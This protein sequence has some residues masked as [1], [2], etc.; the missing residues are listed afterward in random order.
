[1]YIRTQDT[2]PGPF[3]AEPPAKTYTAPITNGGQ[4]I[5]EDDAQKVLTILTG[6]S[7]YQ[8][9]IQPIM[10]AN[11]SKLPKRFLRIVSSVSEVPEHLRAR[12]SSGDNKVVGGTIDRSTGTIYMLPPP[13][14]RSDTR[15]EFAL[16]EAVH[17]LAHPFMGIV[18]ERTFL[19]NY[20]PPCSR[21]TSIGTF[22]RKFCWGPGEGLTQLITEQIM[23]KQNISKTKSER[24]YK[25]MV[26]PVRELMRIYS[27]DA[28]ARAYFWG[29]VRQLTTAIEF[30]WGNGWRIVAHHTSRGETQKALDE[31]KKLE[32]AFERVKSSWPKGDFPDPS[33]YRNLA[34]GPRAGSARLSGL[35]ETSPKP[36][37]TGLRTTTRADKSTPAVVQN[38]I[39]QSPFLKP[40]LA[41]KIGKV[42]IAKNY[43][44]YGSDA[45]FDFAYLKLNK[46]VVPFGSAEEKALLNIRRFFHR[47]NESI[48]LRPTSN[49]GHALQMAI[50]K[51][52]SPGF[53]GFFG[54][55]LD[56]GASLYF[57]NVVLREHR[58]EPLK[59]E[60]ETDQLACITDLVNVAGHALVARAYFQDHSDLVKHLT[61][62]L[63]VGAVRL[64]EIAQ[65]A[66]CKTVLLPTAKFGSHQFKN[67]VAV[68]S[69]GPR[70]VRLWL[71]TDVAGPH[72]IQ[73]FG[74]RLGQTSVKVVVP[75]GQPGDKTLA[76]TY[77]RPAGDPPL[78]PLTRYRYRIVRTSDGTPLG[79]GTFET[80][81]IGDADTP[82]KVSFALLSCH[83]PFNN[84]G[85]VTPEADRMLQLLP[86]ILQENNVKFV[87]PCGD[88]IYADNPGVFS[89]FSNPYLIR[90]AVPG[91][92][93]IFQCT[94]EEVRRVY[95]MRY[96][97]FWSLNPIRKMYANYPCYPAM[98]DHE[99]RGDWG[100]SAEHASARYSSI[101]SG[102][103][104]AYF[105][106][107]AS[108][109]LPPMTR[110]P[111]SFHYDFSYGNIGVFVMDIRSERALHPHY[112]LFSVAQ[113]QD[114]R[115][116]LKNNRDKKAIFIVSSVPVVHLG[117]LLSDIGVKVINPLIGVVGKDID[118]PDHWSVQKNI[119][120][121]NLFLSALHEH[122]QAHPKQ[123][124]AILSGDVHIGNAF[125][126]RWRGRNHPRLYQFT[127]SPLTALFRGFEAD[128]TTLGPR[129][130]TTIGAPAT[131]FGGAC[132]GEVHLLNGVPGANRN[133]FIG[134]NLGLIE[135]TRSGDEVNLKF[136]L[137]GY[138][139]KEDRPVTY[140]ESGV[141]N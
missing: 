39:E 91:K 19:N 133:P 127:S 104:W 82:Q 58:L 115:T 72:E 3:L 33:R 61:G 130:L 63:S 140:F 102:A 56:Q 9:Y 5:R 7:P 54:N 27:F 29:E 55:A 111:R 59:S 131:P 22:Q 141:L 11:G 87:L 117:T 34:L 46:L 4:F 90:Q 92:T 77:P 124:V 120:A 62:K 2:Q 8:K 122:Q 42:S 96:R 112:P 23:E 38:A 94:T 93:D 138:H 83:Q 85:T 28:L 79:D 20:G 81:P 107:Q 86:R 52:S 45:E 41:H 70:S 100:S 50:I 89:I 37:L 32:E 25:D 36:S 110:R 134:L 51:F 74:G 103:L 84:R 114:F 71:R 64:E 99:I 53:R 132:S 40:F 60:G 24:P 125:G 129:L 75:P 66:L 139:P 123:R 6:P 57:A 113:Y 109:V 65:D 119:P 88:Q 137:V 97:T 30:R 108:S 136:K 49:I 98:D 48:H 43:F 21:D 95:D 15:L 35:A 10:A 47:A 67:M 73:I 26:P 126:V 128:V 16:H 116:F 76:I 121:R 105:D 118:F 13:G 68:G 17:L 44:H 1:M 80:S 14:R 78:D 69:T 106:Y 18:D 101:W 135:V 12:F 31:I